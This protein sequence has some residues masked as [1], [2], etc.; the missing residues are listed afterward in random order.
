ML[1]AQARDEAG[2]CQLG[3][4]LDQWIDRAASLAASMLP[5]QPPRDTEVRP[6]FEFQLEPRSTI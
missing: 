5:A 1:F 4:D 6:V 3:L 2:S